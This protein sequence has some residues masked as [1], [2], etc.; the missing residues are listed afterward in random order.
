MN[1]VELK[2]RLKALYGVWMA[3]LKS[4]VRKDQHTK[5]PVSQWG[6]GCAKDM[7]RWS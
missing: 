6:G 4:D 1:D 3:K 5:E 2:A 7:N